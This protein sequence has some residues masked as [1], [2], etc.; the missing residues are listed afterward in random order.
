MNDRH[1]LT[2]DIA[3][4]VEANVAMLRHRLQV[5]PRR[6]WFAGEQD[7]MTAAASA[8]SILKSIDGGAGFA[9]LQSESNSRF[10][11]KI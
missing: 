7:D 3:G 4:T 2:F 11:D 5:D 9:A 1:S 10:L 8:L 6:R